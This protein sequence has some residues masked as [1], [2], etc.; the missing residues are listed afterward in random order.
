[1]AEQMSDV[2]KAR[3]RQLISSEPQSMQSLVGQPPSEA[4]MAEI[5]WLDVIVAVGSALA[6]INS[7]LDAVE[8]V[9]DRLKKLHRW[10]SGDGEDVATFNV[11]ERIVARL[12]RK[13][14]QDQQGLTARELCEQVPASRQQIDASLQE[15]EAHGIVRSSGEAWV[16]RAR[17]LA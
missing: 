15:L 5:P 8:K 2:Q 3:L 11:N 1:M 13:Y 7:Q 9:L 6:L 12:A 17:A 10:L 16:F 4:N 14:L